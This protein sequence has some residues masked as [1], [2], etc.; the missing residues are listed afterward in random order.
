MSTH[1]RHS[2]SHF[3]MC[4]A[5]T[6]SQGLVMENNATYCGRSRLG[7]NPRSLQADSL[8]VKCSMHLIGRAHPFQMRF[9]D[10]LQS[11]DR[12]SSFSCYGLFHSLKSTFIVFIKKKLESHSE[13]PKKQITQITKTFSEYRMMMLTSCFC[14]IRLPYKIYTK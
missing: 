5:P 12:D 8:S 6:K 9:C 4:V 10:N 2:K 7:L 1:S 11:R 14:R 3:E 13:F